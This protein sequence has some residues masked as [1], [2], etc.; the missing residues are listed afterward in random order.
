M[1][2]IL[3]LLFPPELLL[4]PSQVNPGRRLPATLVAPSSYAT[5]LQARP[6]PFDSAE[7]VDRRVLKAEKFA[8]AVPIPRE[9]VERI[10]RETAP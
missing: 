5:L 6:Q 10:E 1:A 3:Y 4:R 7:V 2:F 9:E 8:G